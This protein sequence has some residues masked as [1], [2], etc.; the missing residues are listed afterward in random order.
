MCCKNSW[1]R[2]ITTVF[3]VMLSLAGVA[4]VCFSFI[5][6]FDTNSLLGDSN[7]TVADKNSESAVTSNLVPQNISP[8]SDV[9][10]SDEN[11]D[12]ISSKIAIVSF[13]VGVSAIVFGLTGICTAKIQRCPCTCVFGVMALL[14][15]L[16]YGVAAYLILQ[17]YYVST[18]QIRDFCNDD[19]NLEGKWTLLKRMVEE[20][21]DYVYTVD[22][23]LKYA[24]DTHMCTDFCPC[25]DGWDYSIYGTTNALNFADHENNDYN[26]SGTQTVFTEC[27]QERKTI[28][29]Q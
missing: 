15:T 23:E 22:N 27:W 25:E 12:Q 9:R 21:E 8:V 11:I 13:T 26:F 24:V 6:L 1:S 18:D 19:L 5:L 16:I 20:V 7:V 2:V 17:M 29:L 3:S 4:V 14:V 10:R 28:W